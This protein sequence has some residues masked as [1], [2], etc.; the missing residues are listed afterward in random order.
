MGFFVLLCAAYH[1]APHC[2]SRGSWSLLWGCTQRTC[3]WHWAAGCW[4]AL[5]SESS[6]VVFCCYSWWR[7][8]RNAESHLPA[9]LRK[10]EE[11]EECINL[12]FLNDYNLF[13][14]TD[15]NNGKTHLQLSK[16]K[17]HWGKLIKCSVLNY[18]LGASA[19]QARRFSLNP[20]GSGCDNAES[21]RARKKNGET[22]SGSL[23]GELK[24]GGRDEAGSQRT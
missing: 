16:T 6:S 24:P 19:L 22:V 10:S 7:G 21:S 3:R 12:S 15:N 4:Q 11:R 18:S 5:P 1:S 14:Y 9:N 20:A 17:C 13:N 2:E 23:W 8:C